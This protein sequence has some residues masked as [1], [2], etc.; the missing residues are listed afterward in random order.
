MF[1]PAAA[2]ALPVAAALPAAGALPVVPG[3]GEADVG[4]GLAAGW[5]GLARAALVGLPGLAGLVLAARAAAGGCCVAIPPAAVA[6]PAAAGL[7]CRTARLRGC[8]WAM[9]SF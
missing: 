3:A 4:A 5:P 1:G 7:G 6:G 8:A 9:A 2:G